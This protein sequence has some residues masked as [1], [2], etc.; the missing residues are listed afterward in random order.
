MNEEINTLNILLGFNKQLH[1]LID[2]KLELDIAPGDNKDLFTAF[3]IGKAFKTYEAVG[4]LCR[5]GYGEDAFMLARTL[6]ELMV[7]TWYILQDDTDDRLIRYMNYDWVTRKKMYDYVITKDDLLSGLNKAIESENKE[8]TI[9]EVEAEYKKVME[10]YKYGMGWSDKS[11]KDMSEAIGR[12]DLY[13]TVYSLQCTLG[14][15]NARSMNEYIS[16]TD[17]GTILNIGENWDLVR[18]T[19]VVVFDCFFHIAKQAN[20]RFKWEAGEQM[21]ELSQKWSEEIGKIKH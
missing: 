13:N 3:A 21:E 6:F 16:I 17:E 10:K 14:H 11:I 8:D 9:V 20:E 1:D 7:T 15:T 5:S 2:A 18:T 12:S 4:I 19:L